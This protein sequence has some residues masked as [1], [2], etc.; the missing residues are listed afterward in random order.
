MYIR[1]NEHRPN[2]RKIVNYFQITALYS[3]F[4]HYNKN[5]K[6]YQ[7]KN[8]TY[9]LYTSKQIIRI[10]SNNE[11]IKEYCENINNC[12]DKSNLNIK[13]NI[14]K[15]DI[16]VSFN[17]IYVNIT[18]IF[19]TIGFLNNSDFLKYILYS[20]SYMSTGDFSFYEGGLQKSLVFHDTP[21]HTRS[22]YEAYIQWISNIIKNDN[23]QYNRQRDEQY[24]N[25]NDNI[26]N[27]INDIVKCDYSGNKIYGLLNEINEIE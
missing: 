3:L 22:L 25:I 2:E 26:N 17:N 4:D 7:N 5:N 14:S 15:N 27:D 13:I 6:N 9:K 12:C 1:N 16:I 21:D 24:I 20:K 19:E 18:Y 10:L 8:I 11:K 23:K